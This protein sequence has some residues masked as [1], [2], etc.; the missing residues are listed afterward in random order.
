MDI[1]LSILISHLF[2]VNIREINLFIVRF[3]IDMAY[4]YYFLFNELYIIIM[5]N[6]IYILDNLKMHRI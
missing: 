3:P 5:I 2:I 4:I 1:V 6:N